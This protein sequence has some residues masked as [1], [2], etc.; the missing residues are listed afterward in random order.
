MSI[1]S[2]ITEQ[3]DGLLDLL[4]SQR[5]FG[6][7]SRTRRAMH[8]SLIL[9]F[10]HDGH[11]FGLLQVVFE[12]SEGPASTY[13]VPIMHRSDDHFVDALHDPSF[14]S[15][16]AEGFDSDRSLITATPDSGRLF[17]SV[18]GADHASSWTSRSP[19]VLE[20]EQSNTSVMFGTEA[21]VKVFRKL[22][23]GVNPDSEIV[24]FLSDHHAF[25]HVPTYLG[26]II[27][28]SNGDQEPIEL[29]AVQGFVS[30]QG[31]SWRW[32][33][34]ALGD[35]TAEDR[36]RLLTS[37][38]TLGTRTGELHVAL[39][40]DDGVEEFASI[41]IGHPEV[42]AIE[43]RLG[44]EA[45]NTASM[46]HRQGACSHSESEELASSL[47]ASVSH[48]D[49][50]L[51]TLQTRVHGDYHLGQVLRVGDDFVII[52]FEGEPSRP[53]NERR[54]THSPLKDVAGMLRSIDYAVATATQLST[55][56][57]PRD[58]F[59]WREDAERAFI[60]GYLGVVGRE[61]QALVPAD[62]QAFAEA[63]DIFMIEKALY[64]VRYELDNRPD[65]L[66]I[67]FGALRRIGTGG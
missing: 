33:P 48:A 11:Q 5:W 52:D 64:E 67:P 31:D 66:E 60:D 41:I 25:P 55:S 54:Q 15:W 61:T 51:G 42:D 27:L 57:S 38:R 62:P 28:E 12:F 59:A 49:A 7:K 35:S 22:Q 18:S 53:M 17:W 19:R 4:V 20:G 34:K 56:T 40:D 8:P 3:P 36:T 9:E 47:L 46:L 2:W 16:I 65:W 37:I 39:S 13:F 23:P 6:D 1:K 14:L 26:S 24:A 10:A 32:L 44:R 45:R 29:A 63:L 58:L 43:E 21:I 50:L 30:N